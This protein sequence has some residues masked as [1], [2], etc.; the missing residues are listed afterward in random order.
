M[1]E[2]KEETPL[3][4]DKAIQKTRFRT[5]VIEGTRFRTNLTTKYENR[6][7]WVESQDNK[8]VAIIPGTIVTVFVRKGQKVKEGES[9]LVLESMKMQNQIA[10]PRDGI[11]KS[12]KVAAGQV[13]P[14]GY[15]M[16]ELQ[17]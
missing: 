4:D 1:E 16:I 14:K 12:I 3:N 17:D 11:I 7:K 2:N 13:I 10:C 5:L 8:V 6:G 15:V 9:L